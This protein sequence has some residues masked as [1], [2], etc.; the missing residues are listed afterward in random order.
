MIGPIVDSSCLFFGGLVG[1]LFRKKIAEEIKI[2]LSLIFGVITIALGAKFAAGN[3]DLPIVVLSIIL[4]AFLGELLGLEKRLTI[5]LTKIIGHDFHREKITILIT[6]ISAMCFGTMGF[7]GAINEGVTGDPSVLITKGILDFFT[8]IIFA[9]S[10]GLIVS[11]IAI[12]QFIILASLTI[13]ATTLSNIF[14]NDIIN[15]FNACGGVIFLVTG[16]RLAKIINIQVINM[17]PSLLISIALT[18]IWNIYIKSLL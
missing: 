3:S 11:F 6:L 8:A 17:L 2:N 7:F 9:S 1:Y 4:G 5:L 12:P 14:S 15:N 13:L 18:P 10:L 16:L